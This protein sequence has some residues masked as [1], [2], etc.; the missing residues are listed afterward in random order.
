MSRKHLLGTAALAAA[1]LPAITS[2]PVWAQSTESK[3]ST[4]VSEVI[5]TATRRSE[6]LQDVP[7]SVTAV[8]ADELKQTGAVRFSDVTYTVPNVTIIQNSGAPSFINVSIRGIN[9]RAGI[10]VDDV[11]IG[12]ASGFNTYLIDVDRVEVLRGPQGTLFG[13]NTLAGT[14]NTLTRKPGKTLEAL[15]VVSA[16]NYGQINAAAMVSG[17][18]I[19][20]VLSGSFAATYR[21]R[22]GF[23]KIR[24][25][26]TANDD[27]GFG[28]RAKLRF[29]PNDQLDATL[30]IDTDYTN[31]SPYYYKLTN[32]LTAGAGPVALDPNIH[33]DIVE[34][35][36][37]RNKSARRIN[38]ASLNVTY[39]LSG[40]TLT[41]ITGSRQTHYGL[42]RDA[43]Y[44][45]FNRLFSSS[46]KSFQQTSQEFRIASPD[47]ERFTWLA[48]AFY[49]W[50]KAK[51]N[52]STLVGPDYVISPG[53]TAGMLQA[54]GQL[55][56]PY[57][58]PSTN[59]TTTDT[60]Y[61]AY[62]SANYAITDQ[63]K[64]QAGLRYTSEDIDTLI[65]PATHFSKTEH[66]LSPSLS[67]TYKASEDVNLY[68]TVSQGWYRGG[69]NT[70]AV[71]TVGDRAFR[72]EKLINYELGV[73]SYWFDR[74]LLANAAV[75]Y[76]DYSNLQRT[77][78]F[79]ING[80]QVSTTT[81]AAS[82]TVKGV[83][84][85]LQARPIEGL[86][87]TARYGYQDAS[88]ASYKNAPTFTATGPQTLDLSGT[89]L[90]FAP[91]TSAS[92]IGRYELP[93]GKGWRAWI[94][95]DVGYK[96]AYQLN[97]G[98]VSLVPFFVVKPTTLVDLNLGV[99][100]ED[101]RWSVGLYGR[102]IG[103]ERYKTGLDIATINGASIE[104]DQFSDPATY[105]VEVRFKY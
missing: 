91:K 100:T 104:A 23:S 46:T 52:G 53:V 27:N 26:G 49:F 63:L 30:S 71:I 18:L 85:E 36:P 68:G 81:N 47:H 15:G 93:I 16:G 65:K 103:D 48:G 55:P 87:L 22:D 4:Q 24:T 3:S 19:S 84:L 70:Q 75:F 43:D 62:G 14:I 34:G 12:E 86:S 97:S 82:T 60:S 51:T 102:N 38:G 95:G 8:G 41:S 80:A 39:D 28:A 69:F 72:P 92:L 66:N 9:G 57:I 44:T 79:L 17:P 37:Q 13:T 33:D 58:I 10:Y 45:A 77:Q 40:Y 11:P 67:V 105:L 50:S 98:P 32:Q 21:D 25:G 1:I 76:M 89:S 99:E 96:S 29:T 90:P 59:N 54:A 94:A 20:D 42:A 7:L 61:A 35:G 2:S 31:V 6:K 88:Y 83:E 73:K 74:R 101:G 64:V 56:N 5:V 78:G